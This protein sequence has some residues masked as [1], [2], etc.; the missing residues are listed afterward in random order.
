MTGTWRFSYEAVKASN[1]FFATG[2]LNIFMRGFLGDH[3]D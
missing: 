2:G 1:C 3:G